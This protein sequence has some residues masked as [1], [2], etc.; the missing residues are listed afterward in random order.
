ML[1]LGA[2]GDGSIA[3][4]LTGYGQ[5]PERQQQAMLCAALGPLRALPAR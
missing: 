3:C 2:L 1:D 5:T 4:R